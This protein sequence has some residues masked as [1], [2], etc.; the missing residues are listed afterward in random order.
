M[1]P[2]HPMLVHFPIALTIFGLIADLS[3]DVLKRP[4]LYLVGYWS[5]TAAAIA[6]GLTVGAGYIDMS[7]V[8]LSPEV[9]GYLH[10][11]VRIGW[12]LLAA[13]VVLAL[14]RWLAAQSLRQMH[15]VIYRSA[16]VLVVMLILFQAWYGGEM[17]YVYGSSVVAAGHGVEAPEPA[18][19]RLFRSTSFLVRLAAMD[20]AR[21]TQ[22]RKR[23]SEAAF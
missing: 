7:R 18:R 16:S 4:T 1:P 19:R 5:V 21:P 9:D 6:A 2:L 12:L 3:G 17:V 23:C 14:W 11:H 10:L 15:R 8:S 13:L 22:E 20:M